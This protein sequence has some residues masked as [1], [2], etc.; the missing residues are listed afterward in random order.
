[1]GRNTKKCKKELLK[2]M[3]KIYKNPLMGITSKSFD[4]GWIKIS[5]EYF[6]RL[7][8][9]TGEK[10]PFPVVE[11]YLTTA[12]RCPYSPNK[13]PPYFFINFFSNIPNALHTMGHEIMHI[14][15]H[16]INWWKKVEDE[17]GNNKTHDLK[18]ALTKL[19]DLEFKDL[20]IVKERGYPSHEK[21]REYIAEQWKKKKDFDNLTNKCIKWIKKNGI[22]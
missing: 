18:E 17:I 22:K 15:L 14:H 12:A 13:R 1:M 6:K 16:N 4:E 2:T 21:L 9:M 8:K 7:E 5:P 3:G 19:L 10:F 11:A 20:W